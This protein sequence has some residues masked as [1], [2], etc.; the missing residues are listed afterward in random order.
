MING[1]RVLGLILA[2]GGSTRL[3]RKNVREC[4]GL[5]LI[6]WTVMAA[7]R[8]RYIDH[9]VC[10]TDNK[11]IAEAATAR[12]GCTVI[13]RPAHL[14]TGDATSIEAVRHAMSMCHDHYDIVVL[15]QPT[16]PLRTE[17][18]IDSALELG[19]FVIS[20][21]NG[22][23]NGAIYIAPGEWLWTHDFEDNASHNYE[24]PPERSVDIDTEED[25]KKA[26]E[27][28]NPELAYWAMP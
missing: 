6:Q 20:T 24:M 3:T 21:C 4:G 5:P 26:S 13:D 1:K 17:D 16:S 8:S 27:L 12:G 9:I 28:L 11:E 22:K 18:D 2:R 14:A 23:R 25:L 10:S 15:L 7:N 19:S